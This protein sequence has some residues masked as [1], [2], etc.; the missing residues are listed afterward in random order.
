M[1]NVMGV[2]KTERSGSEENLTVDVCPTRPYCWMLKDDRIVDEVNHL[3][4]RDFLEKLKARDPQ[5]W[6][7]VK[8]LI[9][10]PIFRHQ[11][12]AEMAKEMSIEVGDA[13]GYLCLTM[14]QGER[15]NRSRNPNK[16]KSWMQ[17]YVRKFIRGFFT[18]KEKRLVSAEAHF[19]K[20]MQKTDR[21]GE[22]IVEDP[23][24]RISDA[25]QEAKRRE[26][27]AFDEK[28]LIQ[29]EFHKLWKKD[30]QKAYVLMFK[31]RD[32]LSSKDIQKICKISSQANVDQLFGRAKKDMS[33][34]LAPK[35]LGKNQGKGR[36][37]HV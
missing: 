11:K 27:L 15:L 13:Y 29:D 20:V 34:A 33:V 1:R 17:S 35:L 16:L 31:M 9:V 23:I 25:R 22:H 8:T 6:A 32:G 36:C 14:L 3:G 10:E 5:A 18:P 21:G 4:P 19:G 26:A 2:S 7:S 28:V 12:Y 37:C 30:P 24:T